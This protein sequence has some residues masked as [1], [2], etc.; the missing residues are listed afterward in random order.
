MPARAARHPAVTVTDRPTR[1]VWECAADQYRRVWFSRRRIPAPDAIDLAV[2][3]RLGASLVTFDRRMADNART[4]GI[5][6]AA[7]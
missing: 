4:L 5:A 6:A 3:Q 7:V 2:A 1:G